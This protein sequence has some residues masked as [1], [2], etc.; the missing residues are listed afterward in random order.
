MNNVPIVAVLAVYARENGQGMVFG[1]EPG[2]PKPGDLPVLQK[3]AESVAPKLQS[4]T[5]KKQ[6]I[7]DDSSELPEG[8]DDKPPTSK[9]TLKVIK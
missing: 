3:V 4:V 9:P 5:D 7:A 6:G 8:P 1:T 2:A